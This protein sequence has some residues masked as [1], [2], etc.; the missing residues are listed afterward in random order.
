MTKFKITPTP[1]ENLL[2][3]KP[4]ILGESRDFL[5]DLAAEE[6]EQ[7]SFAEQG[8]AHHTHETLARG[9]MR[10][11]YF[12]RKDSYGRMIAVKSGRVLA[13][14]VD[15]RPESKDFGA[16]HSVEL[17]S[18]NEAMLYIPPYFAHGF[19]TLEPKTEVVV[20]SV[21]TPN[22]DEYSGIIWD[23]EILAINWQFERYEIDEKRLSILGRDKNLPSFRSYNHNS[24]WINRPKKSKYAL[25]DSLKAPKI[26]E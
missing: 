1:L 22:P 26:R 14:A 17:N 21:A 8:F 9:V 19:L 3:L 15:L 7:L 18:E 11:L 16:A 24:I 6:Y 10:G 20:N 23:D 12:Q 25:K 13:V 2:L 5:F 4:E